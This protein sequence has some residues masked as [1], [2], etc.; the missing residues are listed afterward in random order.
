MP[1]ANIPASR[2]DVHN[3]QVPVV[4]RSCEARH[5][6]ICGVLTA[7]QLTHLSR[8]ASR[9]VFNADQEMIAPG[10]TSHRHGAILGGV[11]KLTKLLGDGRQQIVALQFAPDY[12]GRPFKRESEVGAQAATEVR[13]C[14]FPKSTIEDLIRRSPELEHR[15]HEQSLKELDEAR[16]WMVT[17]GRKNANEKVASFLHLIAS[18]IDPERS[19]GAIRFELPLKRADIADFLGLTIETVS[20]QLTKLRNAG[21]V[22]IENN[23]SVVVPDAERLRNASG[24]G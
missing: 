11:V 14:S 3:S 6:G 22:E 2:L 20:R 16:D 1:N 9:Q 12:L 23:R 19:G 21:I 17:L 4:C 5:R 7:D 8:Q 10:A 24:N 13:V 18:H 15:L